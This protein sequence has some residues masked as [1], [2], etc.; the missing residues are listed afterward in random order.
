MKDIPNYSGNPINAFTLIKR[1][2]TD[3]ELI[4]KDMDSGSG[5]HQCLCVCAFFVR[6]ISKSIYSRY[7]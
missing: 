3:L 6:N 7:F 4:Q 1:L 2:T 5:K